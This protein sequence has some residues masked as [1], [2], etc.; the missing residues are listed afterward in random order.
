MTSKLLINTI[1]YYYLYINFFCFRTFIVNYNKES[2]S[3]QTCDMFCSSNSSLEVY[4]NNTLNYESFTSYNNNTSMS[5]KSWTLKLKP[6]TYNDALNCINK[7]NNI[8]YNNQFKFQHNNII[9]NIRRG[10]LSLSFPVGNDL[11]F[12]S[13]ENSIVLEPLNQPPSYLMA[14]KW[15]E[16]HNLKNKRKRKIVQSN[17][18]KGFLT[19]ESNSK[20]KLLKIINNSTPNSSQNKLYTSSPHTPMR[21]ENQKLKTK[22]KLSTLFLDSLNVST[23]LLYSVLNNV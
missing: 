7:V 1:F 15:L 17:K 19:P 9:E 13:S 11:N 20:S 8:Q 4:D 16:I 6:P 12:F 22:R 10:L 2:N 3:N 23:F 5:S 18:L 21:R 14:F